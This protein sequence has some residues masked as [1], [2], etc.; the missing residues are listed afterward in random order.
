MLERE[1]ALEA[2]T[3]ERFDVVVVGGGV[4]GAGV[5]LDAA[6]RGYSV[7][8]VERN[9]W[10]IGT[11]SR[12]SKMVHGGLRYLENFD[13]GLVREALLERQLMVQLAPHLVYPTPFLVPAFGEGRLSRTLG[14]GLNMYDVMAS[15]RVGQAR[16]DREARVGAGDYWAPDRHRV[17][18]GEEAIELVPAL[19]PLEPSEA[20]LFY[21][22]QTDDVRLVLTILGEAE[23]FGA[24]CLNR[25]EV[26]GLREE[27]GIATGVLCVDSESGSEFEVEADNVINATGVWADRIR[28]E[29][30]HDEAEVPRISPSRGTHLTLPAG[31]L[32]LA[33][34]A[35][36]VPAGAERRIFA[37]PWY[38]QALIGTTDNDFDGD[39]M[40]P[41]PGAEDI[42]Y[43]LSA[44]NEFFGRDLGP[45]DVTGAYAGV[46]PLISTGDPR[47]S[48][49]IS[50]KAELY[51]TS[52]GL[53][54]ITGGKLTT[55]RRMA[56]QVVDRMVER[57]GRV[58]P[59]RTADIPLGMAAGEGELDPPEGLDEAD[60]PDGYRELLGFRYG[61]AGRRV[62]QIAGQEKGL[63]AP[64]VEGHPDL[65][66]EA[67]VAARLEQART[68]G[69][70]LLRRTRLGLLA[71]P[72][73]R[74]A[75]AVRPVAAAM[76]A[77]LGW[78]DR[79]VDS[80][81]EAW[82]EEARLEGIDP[83]NGVS[84]AA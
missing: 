23:R 36:I 75:G 51:E 72:Q 7:A 56:K 30:I 41:E 65:L 45:A 16:R 28:P 57:A 32:D 8:I 42:D 14:I 76:G 25:A 69:D 6:S 38:G 22:C 13:L 48:V 82:L 83:A 11:S 35:L 78:D 20:Y 79:R 58:A 24:L 34:G 81:A 10:A 61:H 67:V 77:E 55:W 17:I 62:L 18:P 63:A 54:T 31:K 2:I 64:I 53:L 27:D 68:V 33:Q 37:L 60:L 71:A 47:K 26:R 40:R 74:S 44:V 80:E 3:A 29:E 39:I 49:D 52:S 4:T 59:C 1:K 5:A 12:S 50:R 43:L 9:D 84:S 21:D 15:T 66:A 46:R 73:L 19:G 70:V